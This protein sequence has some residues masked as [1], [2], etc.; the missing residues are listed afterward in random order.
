M[1][2]TELRFFSCFLTEPKPPP[3]SSENGESRKHGSKNWKENL[4]L[5]SKIMGEMLAM[6]KNLSSIA[7]HSNTSDSAAKHKN[8]EVVMEEKWKSVARIVD[9]HCMVAYITLMLLFHLVIGLVV[10]FGA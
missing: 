4:S 10:A 7:A 2:H 3:A 1:W 9:F 5:L 6:S 8:A